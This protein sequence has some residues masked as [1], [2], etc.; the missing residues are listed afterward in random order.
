MAD[1]N[2]T[3]GH[4]GC[5]CAVSGDDEFCSQHCEEAADQDMTEIMCDCGHPGCG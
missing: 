2:N 3:C 5:G 4:E 1:E